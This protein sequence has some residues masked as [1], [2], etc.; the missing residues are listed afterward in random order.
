MA[1]SRTQGQ[2]TNLKNEA[3]VLGHITMKEPPERLMHWAYPA[4]DTKNKYPDQ[5]DCFTSERSTFVSETLISRG[6]RD[7]EV[8]LEECILAAEVVVPVPL[9]RV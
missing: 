1:K 3:V 6:G 5:N 2:F 8:V 7:S 4:T 9:R